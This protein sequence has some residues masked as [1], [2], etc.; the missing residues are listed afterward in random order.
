MRGMAA[1]TGISR[2]GGS[3]SHAAPYGVD[4]QVRESRPPCR[5]LMSS[6][7]VLHRCKGWRPARGSLATA[8]AVDPAPTRLRE[9]PYGVDDEVRESRSSLPPA[10][11]DEDAERGANVNGASLGLARAVTPLSLVHARRCFVCVHWISLLL[12]SDLSYCS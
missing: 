4:G 8:A 1:G 11:E 2:D 9:L 7:G 12:G 6:S 3:P 5:P 10:D